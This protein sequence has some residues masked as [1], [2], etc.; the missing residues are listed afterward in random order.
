MWVLK[1]VLEIKDEERYS[2]P[3]KE[4]RLISVAEQRKNL[5]L[6]FETDA[7]EDE[8]ISRNKQAVGTIYIVGTGQQ[9]E[10]IPP[11]AKFIGTVV[12]S[13]GLVWHCYGKTEV[14]EK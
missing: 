4:I 12:M 14:S 9:R 2:F 3:G 13:Y 11:D 5:V 10:D 1:Q 8:I 6:Y 7:T